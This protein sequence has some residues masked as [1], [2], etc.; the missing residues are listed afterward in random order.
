MCACAALCGVRLMADIIRVSPVKASKVQHVATFDAFSWD[1]LTSFARRITSSSSSP[2]S[3]LESTRCPRLLQLP[4]AARR[5]WRA[6][7]GRRAVG[8]RRRRQLA[9]SKTGKSVSV[10]LRHSI[11]LSLSISYSSPNCAY[12]FL[13]R[14]VHSSNSSRHKHARTYAPSLSDRRQVST[15][16]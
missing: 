15:E 2:A 8:K 4:D 16:V 9:E 11:C 3:R 12:F 14:L 13:S 7:N 10:A 1:L 5:S 6:L